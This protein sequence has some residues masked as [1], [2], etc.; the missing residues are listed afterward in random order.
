MPEIVL[1][2]ALGLGIRTR[3]V[4]QASASSCA[5]SCGDDFA[6]SL[7]VVDRTLF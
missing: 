2:G 3:P 7:D 5:L 6:S 4:S 1:A